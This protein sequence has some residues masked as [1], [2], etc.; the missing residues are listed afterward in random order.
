MDGM[1][2]ESGGVCIAVVLAARVQN[3]AWGWDF[4]SL[5]MC[6]ARLGEPQT[7]VDML[8]HKSGG[9]QF[10]VHGLATGRPFAYFFPP[11]SCMPLQ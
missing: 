9:F 4:P 5:A 1:A 8:L 11:V 10:D 3:R 6:A 7:A 2:K